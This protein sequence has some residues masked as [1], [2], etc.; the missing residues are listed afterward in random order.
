MLQVPRVFAAGTRQQQEMLH[1]DKLHQLPSKR[2]VLMCSREAS[3]ITLSM[4][5]PQRLSG[6]MASLDT[7]TLSGRSNLSAMRV[8]AKPRI[9]P[10]HRRCVSRSLASLNVPTLRSKGGSAGAVRT[11]GRARKS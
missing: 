4:M 10:D 1:R 11:A 2:C 6:A 5:V 3:D 7:P 8:A 9:T